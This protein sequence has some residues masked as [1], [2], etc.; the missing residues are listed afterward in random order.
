MSN[1]LK[2][3]FLSEDEYLE[4]EGLAQQRSE[5][6]RGEVYAMT[7]GSARHNRISLNLS[8]RLDAASRGTPCE[9]FMADMKVRLPAHQAFYYPDVFVACRPDDD[10]PLYRSAPCLIAEVLSPSTAK[11]DQREKWQ[12]Y[13]DIPE[14]RYYLMIDSEA[15]R[16][17]VLS[18]DG[19]GWLEQEL[20]EDDLVTIECGGMRVLL[21]FDD[22]YD[23]TGLEP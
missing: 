8:M 3:T 1:A 5:F 4:G 16:V 17:R 14:L 2:K 19:D 22:L 21:G 7:G 20:G 10:H 18:R 6:V 9:V 12:H 11:I 13:R 23:R 15:R